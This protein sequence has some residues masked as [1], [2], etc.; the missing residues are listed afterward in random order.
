MRNMAS[1]LLVE[2]EVALLG[3]RIAATLEMKM[4]EVEGDGKNAITMKR[5]SLE[6]CSTEIKLCIR[7]CKCMLDLIYA[8][9]NKNKVAHL[10]AKKG[11]PIYL[12]YGWI[13]LH[14]GYP[15]L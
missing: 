12:L 1:S 10:L 11:L 15:K 6:K 7:D 4:L 3:L 8:S 9:R 2:C 14:Y 13:I 5:E